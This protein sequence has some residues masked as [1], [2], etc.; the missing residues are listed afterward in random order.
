MIDQEKFIKERMI[1]EVK[2]LIEKGFP[3]VAVGLIA[4]Y[5]ETLGAFLDKKPFKTPRQSSVRF[6]LALEK[7][8]PPR[9]YSLNKKGFLYKQLR[10]NFTHLGIESQFL[11]F[12]FDNKNPGSHLKF[13]N[14]KTTFVI[15]NLSE[16]YVK[17]CNI[18]IEMLKSNEIKAKK[19]A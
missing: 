19:L 12:D 2:A 11:T 7:L 13:K 4:Q 10:S 5:I 3:R 18:I 1:N 8:F 15:D 14:G 9:Y 17:A 6:D 16:D